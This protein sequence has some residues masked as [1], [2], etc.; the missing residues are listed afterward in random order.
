MA[1]PNTYFRGR[2]R[3]PSA[4]RPGYDYGSPGYYFVTIITK[5]RIWWFGEPARDHRNRAVIMLSDIGRVAA[6]EWCRTADVRPYVEL[7]EWIIM[8]DHVHGIVVIRD[9]TTMA[10]SETGDNDTNDGEPVETRR[11]AS[12]RGPQPTNNQNHPNQFGP[13]R[14][15]LPSI[16]R[17]F[18]T[19]V[20]TRVRRSVDSTFAWQPRYH[21]RVIRN[22]PEMNRIR[23]YIRNNPEQLG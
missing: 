17:G 1:D 19:A 22:R 2:Y 6:G 4:R 23:R 21:D 14:H 18:K 5:N 15:N 11:H 12:L 13:Q 9:R 3:I 8:P 16:V 10:E 7:D 20:T